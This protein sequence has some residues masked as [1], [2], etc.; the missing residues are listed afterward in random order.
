MQKFVISF[1]LITLSFFSFSKASTQAALGPSAGKAEAVLVQME[2][3]GKEINSLVASIWQQKTNT[4]LGIDDPPE[5]GTIY[6]QPGKNGQMKLRI[7]I[8]KPAKTIVISGDKLKF[9]QKGVQQMI[10]ASIKNASKNQSAASLAITFGSVSAIRSS[11]NVTYVKD[12]KVGAE[13]TSLL[14]LEPKQKGPYKSID[15]WISQSAW[16]PVQQR[17]VE[18]NDDVTIVRLS[19]LKKNQQ[20]DVKK[21]IDNFSP[22]DAK[23]V[24]G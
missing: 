20:F 4:Q 6:Y 18:S 24:Q 22:S 2:S 14:H 7:D 11:Y 13:M 17:F 8:E 3:V 12:E 19:N 21:L 1:A 10:V 23:I 9:Y 5:S 16:L 15:I